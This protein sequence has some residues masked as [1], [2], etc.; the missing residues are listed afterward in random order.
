M[1]WDRLKK[2]NEEAYTY[3]K[4]LTPKEKEA[5]LYTGDRPTKL[6]AGSDW[7]PPET[8]TELFNFSKTPQGRDWWNAVNTEANLRPI[9]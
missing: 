3:L 7:Q 2:S 8:L 9:D 5:I 6:P 1:K 4:N